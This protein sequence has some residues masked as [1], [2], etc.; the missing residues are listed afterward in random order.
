MAGVS[1][2]RKKMARSGRARLHGSWLLPGMNPMIVEYLSPKNTQNPQPQFKGKMLPVYVPLSAKD[3]IHGDQPVHNAEILTR[4]EFL[5]RD[6]AESAKDG[7]IAS[8]YRTY[9]LAWACLAAM[10]FSYLYVH[11]YVAAVFAYGAGYY[12]AWKQ[13]GIG[14]SREWYKGK[15]LIH[16]T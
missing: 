13:L 2:V 11:V 1:E 16:T 14:W 12:W 10:A 6:F 8:S 9:F 7:T 15:M 4:E 5:N 3:K